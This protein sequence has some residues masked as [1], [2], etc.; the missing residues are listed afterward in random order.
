METFR[1]VPLLESMVRGTEG[2]FAHDEPWGYEMKGG[3]S[4]TSLYDGSATEHVRRQHVC[5]WGE[6]H[7]LTSPLRD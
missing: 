2:L 5:R 3:G 7:L 1:N 6:M 4:W